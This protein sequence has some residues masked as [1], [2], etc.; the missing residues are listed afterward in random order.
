[1]CGINGFSSS[2]KQLIEEMNRRIKHRGP[3]DDGIY[4]DEKVSLGQ[5]RL[6]I[7]D[8]SSAGH[9]PMSYEHKGRK[10][11]IV[12]N[13]EIYNFQ[14]IRDDLEAK[15]YSFKSKTDTEVIL[16]SYLEYGTK[17][18]EAFNGMWGFV[19]YDPEK[20]HLFCSR[21]RLGV[22]PLYYYWDQ[23]SFIFSSELKGLLAHEH[24]KI[25]QAEN[26]NHDAV[27][28]FFSVGFVPSPTT[29]FKNVYKLEPR[30]NLLF[31]LKENS[32][33]TEYY[34]DIPTFRP[35][36]NHEALVKEG[37]EL[38]CDA[39]RLRMIAD[40]PV[41]AFLSGGLDS[42]AVVGLMQEHT[43]LSKLHTFSICLLYTSPSPRDH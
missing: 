30:Q 11:Y 39:I 14:D 10:V 19:I 20:N 5:V 41:G 15:G 38:L 8:L 34:F 32:L 40:V 18:V 36:Y 4:T 33:S 35:E 7:I 6:S 42:S 27:D 2:N 25:N 12:F 29:I 17:C 24:L 31:N 13:G 1:M 22:K 28:Y 37:R 43:D 3:D 9:Q 23:K 21:D 26:I 16:A